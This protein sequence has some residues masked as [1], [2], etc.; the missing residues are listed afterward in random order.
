MALYQ[1]SA[2]G[3][4]NTFSLLT[5]H[6]WMLSQDPLV[7]LFLHILQDSPIDFQHAR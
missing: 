5:R 2:I 1:H 4:I 3:T 6:V 7:S